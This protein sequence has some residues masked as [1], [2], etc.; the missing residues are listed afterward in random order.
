MITKQRYDLVASIYLSPRGYGFVIAEGPENPV[1]W[2]TSEVN[3][4]DKNRKCLLGIKALVSRYHPDL[5]ILEDVKASSAPRSKRVVD[6][7]TNIAEFAIEHGVP[8][9]FVSRD[10]MRQAFRQR[11]ADTKDEIAEVIGERIP[12]LLSYVPPVRKPWMSVHS[13]MA[14]FDAAALLLTAAANNFRSNRSSS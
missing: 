12:V 8:I 4:S 9:E 11:G 14:L 13:R 10:M 3:G 7:T 1:D 5:L 2:G 6:L